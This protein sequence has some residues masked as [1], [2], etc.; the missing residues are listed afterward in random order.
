MTPRDIATHID[1]TLNVEQGEEL[2]Q[3]YADKQTIQVLEEFIQNKQYTFFEDA[4]TDMLSKIE[5][6]KNA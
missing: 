2:I 1:L 5:E 3:E 6:I 4:V